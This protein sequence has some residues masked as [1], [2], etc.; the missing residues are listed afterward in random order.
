MN[1]RLN[2]NQC[3]PKTVSRRTTYSCRGGNEPLDAGENT[4]NCGA[5]EKPLDDS[6]SDD[7]PLIKLTPFCKETGKTGGEN[8]NSF[9]AGS[10]SSRLLNY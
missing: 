3:N 4:V 6:L 7:V 1:R 5:S 2:L 9:R 10:T 8:C